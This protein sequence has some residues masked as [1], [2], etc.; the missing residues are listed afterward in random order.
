MSL[1]MPVKGP[2]AYS[3][4]WYSLRLF[5]P[6]RRERPV[7]FGASEAASACGLSPYE[8]TLQLY[9]TKRGEWSHEFSSSQQD[10]MDIGK[11]LEPAI[12]NLYEKRQGCFTNRNLPMYF[13]P[14]HS[15][16]GATPDAIGFNESRDSADFTEWSVD[17]KS[18]G[19]RMLDK[20]GDDHSKYGADGTDQIPL[21]NLC[22]AQVQMAVMGLSRCDF[23]V[24]VDNRDFRVYRVNRDDEFIG[25]IVSAMKELSER[26]INADPPEPNWQHSGIVKVIRGMF[27]TEVGKVASLSEEDH[28][29]WIRR[30]QLKSEV[31]LKE[32]E[33]N[34]I[35]AQLAWAMED[36]EIGRFPDATIELK[37]ITVGECE[38]PAYVR[39][40]YS[41]LKPRKIG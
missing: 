7:V 37:K 27:G 10:R 32:E 24:L 18:T 29:L 5:N 39:K 9:L 35:D 3:E 4:S 33:I 30:A 13:H 36:A 22:Q 23:P 26:I 17:A 21:T 41:Y 2:E 20:T 31:S 11:E 12:L 40:G 25:S 34:E 15:F 19:W 14:D 16:M 8:S 6:D 38:V 1:H 28:D